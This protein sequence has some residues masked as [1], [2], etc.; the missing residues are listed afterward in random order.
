MSQLQNHGVEQLV[1]TTP[2]SPVVPGS[3]VRLVDDRSSWG[4]VISVAGQVTVL[5][6]REP[7]PELP[8]KAGVGLPVPR[9]ASWTIHSE[10]DWTFRDGSSVRRQL[11]TFEGIEEY[12]RCH[13]IDNLL[14]R[15]GGRVTYTPDSIIV[16]RSTDRL[17]DYL[18]NPDGSFNATY[19]R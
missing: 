6:T 11:P 10:P 13:S 9:Q 16:E 4:T 2:G 18:R 8:G 3:I 19:R 7:K 1:A 17:P 5:W 12:D 15:T 14:D